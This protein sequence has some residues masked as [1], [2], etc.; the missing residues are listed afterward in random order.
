MERDSLML[1]YSE[2]MKWRKRSM[3]RVCRILIVFVVMAM[4]FVAPPPF[5]CRCFGR[6]EC[7][8]TDCG[9]N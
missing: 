7:S 9:T 4:M 2:L 5:G 6:R 8:W 1:K 3:E